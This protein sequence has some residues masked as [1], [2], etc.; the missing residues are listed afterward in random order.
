MK[1][2]NIVGSIR[3]G[4]FGYKIRNKFFVKNELSKIK[5]REDF[6]YKKLNKKYEKII[7]SSNYKYIKN[8]ES[9]YIWIC[10]LQ[11]YDNAPNIVKSCINSIKKEFPEKEIIIITNENIDKYITFPSYVIKNFKDG[12]MGFAHYSDLIRT[13]LLCNY[14]GIW[15]D[16]TVL[17]TSDS[18]KNI[19]NENDFFVFK[20]M[21][22][23]R[24]KDQTIVASSWFIYSK[25]KE[26]PIMMLT[27]DL[28]Y[29][30]WNDF[31]YLMDYFLFHIMFTM[32]TKRYAEEWEEMS[33]YN[34]HSPHVLMF[35]LNKKYT[36]NRWEEIKQISPIH[37]LQRH[38]DYS[39]NKESFYKFIIDIYLDKEK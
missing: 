31:D 33:T 15:I 11:G 3:R 28:L 37:K 1:V 24:T 27:R 20:S 17:C 14:G 4:E 12:K 39:D 23:N 6:V 38:I 32:S 35:E 34:N 7:N 10:W 13:E 5:E 22:L 36:K 29:A 30:Y 16:S 2:S 26:E 18:I 19:L 8:N 25:Y 21:D 9:N